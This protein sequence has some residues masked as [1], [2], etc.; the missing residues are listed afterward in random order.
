[1]PTPTYALRFYRID[2]QVKV[3][4]NNAQAWASDVIHFN[5][6]LDIYLPLDDFLQ[7]GENPTTIEIWNAAP[8]SPDAPNPWQLRYQ[9]EIKGIVAG[10]ND[11]SGLHASPG[12]MATKVHKFAWPYKD[13]FDD[14]PTVAV[15][16]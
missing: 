16:L 5:P 3:I 13:E 1:M 11:L 4:I 7:P 10:V 15:E 2:N 8:L 14:N 12:L 9:I 6:P